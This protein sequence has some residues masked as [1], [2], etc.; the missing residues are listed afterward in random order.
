M[1]ETEAPKWWDEFMEKMKEDH[2]KAIDLFNELDTESANIIEEM[3]KGKKI[4]VPLHYDKKGGDK[5]V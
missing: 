2:I 5:N 4:I 1:D 3:L